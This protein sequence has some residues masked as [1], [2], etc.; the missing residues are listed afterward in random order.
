MSVSGESRTKKGL[1]SVK[2]LSFSGRSGYWREWSTKVLAYGRTKG[3]ESALTD[4]NA[5]KESKDEALNFLIMS[6]TGNAFIFVSHAKDPYL[7]WQELCS[8]YEPTEDMDLYDIKET[9][10]NC[11]L[12]HDTENVSIWLKRLENINKRLHEVD[13]SHSV[14]DSD[15]K[16]HIKANLPKKLYKVFL[17]TNRKNFKGMTYDELKKDLK[18]YW[19]QSIKINDGDFGDEEED[20]LAVEM[21]RRKV[22]RQ[23][24]NY[25][26]PF[27]GTCFN[28]GQIG[29]KSRD[30][31]EKKQKNKKRFDKTKVKCFKCGEYGHYASECKKDKTE[32]NW[33]VGMIE[34][35]ELTS[36]PDSDYG[37]EWTEVT[38]GGYHAN[39][40]VESSDEELEVLGTTNRYE[41]LSCE[42][43]EDWQPVLDNRVTVDLT[44]SEDESVNKLFS[45]DSEDEEREADA[46]DD[47]MKAEVVVITDGKDD[48]TAVKKGKVKSEKCNFVRYETHGEHNNVHT[49]KCRRRRTR[50]VMK[51]KQQNREKRNVCFEKRRKLRESFNDLQCKID[52]LA[53][54]L[55]LK[56]NNDINKFSID[57]DKT[58]KT[59]LSLRLSN[60]RNRL[61][62]ERERVCDCHHHHGRC[63]FHK[64]YLAMSNEKVTRLNQ[65]SDSVL[66]IDDGKHMG[67]GTYE[68]WL[69]DSGSTVHVTNVNQF[70]FNI[71]RTNSVVT[72]GT[73]NTVR[74]KYSGSVIIQQDK[75]QSVIVLNNVL[76]VPEF[77]QNII[78]VNSLLRQGYRMECDN[79][80]INLMHKTKALE[81]TKDN[82]HSM[83][84]L[85]GIRKEKNKNVRT[86]NKSVCNNLNAHKLDIQRKDESITPEALKD[87]VISMDIN[88]AHDSFGHVSEE[89]LRRF[90]KEHNIKLTGKMRTC[91]GC[92]EAK[93]KRKPVQKQ[94]EMRATRPCERIFIDTSGPHPQ[95]LRRYK[96]WIKIVDDFSR[97]NWNYFAKA[98]SE[99]PRIL[100]RFILM[101]KAQKKI[102]K[103]VRCDNAGEHMSE[104]Q[105]VCRKYQIKPEYVAPYTPQHNG[106]VERSFTT[107]LW[108]MKAMLRQ[109][110]F[111]QAT[112]HMFWPHAILVL[113]KI[114][115]M[116]YTS[117]NRGGKTPDQLFGCSSPD[118]SRH[119]I[120]FGRVGYVTIR[121]K[122]QGKM[123]P[124][125]HKCVMVGYADNHSADTYL[126]FNPKTRHI[127][128]SRDI[129]WAD[130]DRPKAIDDLNMYKT[131]EED[132]NEKH[133][134]S[135]PT[136]IEDNISEQGGRNVNDV[137]VENNNDSNSD[138]EIYI[139]IDSE[140]ESETE[141][142]I[143]DD[144][145]YESIDNNESEDNNQT[146]R[147]TD[148]T[149]RSNRSSNRISQQVERTR[150]VQRA[151]RKLDTSF[152]SEARKRLRGMN[153]TVHKI[154]NTAVISDPGEPKDIWEAIKEEKKTL[155]IPSIKAEI[156]NFV[157]RKSWEYVSKHEPEK[158]NR[159]LIPCKWVFKVKDEQDGSKRYKS[160]LCV[161]GFHQIPGVDY[162][163]SFSPVA[164]DATI[165][166][167]LLYT[168]WKYTEGWR[169][170][171][172]D[173]EAAFLNAE[174]ETPMYLKWPEAMYELGCITKHQLDNECIKLVRSMYGNVDAA[175]RWQKCFI[176]A[177]TD[178][179]GE[180]KCEQSKVDPCL[181][182]KRNEKNEVILLIVCYV[183][184]ILFSGTKEQIEW[185]K[186]TFKKLYKITELG[187][188]KKHLGMWYDWKKD[189]NGETYIKVTMDKM[190]KE[191]VEMYEKVTGKKVKDQNT[192]GYPNKC[193]TKLKDESQ[194][195]KVKE[196]RSL[197]GKILYYVNKMDVAC[198]NAVRELAQHLDSPG[199]EHWKALSRLVGYIKT[200]IGVG[201]IIRKP[202]ELRVVGWSDSDYAKREDRKSIGGNISTIGGSAVFGSSKGQSCVCLSS[203]EAE[204]V[205]MGT[206]AQ[207]IRFEQQL[208]DE[209]VGDEQIYPSIIYED[210]VGAIFLAQNRQVGQRTKHIDV[211]D[212]FIRGL[213]EAK[214]I[215]IVF[216]RSEDNYADILTKN[217]NQ[218]L[219][220]KHAND[221]DQGRLKYNS[222]PEKVVTIERD[223]LWMK[224]ERHFC[225]S[226]RNNI[227][228][229]EYIQEEN[230]SSQNEAT[231]RAE[232]VEEN[233]INDD[234]DESDDEQVNDVEESRSNTS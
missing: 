133:Q 195:F 194:I 172:F 2:S 144:N 220:K 226:I 175:L 80:R 99:V 39:A 59:Y 167:L 68:S 149:Q 51:R 19:R 154:Y 105:E 94:T 190:I 1:T 143:I 53:K 32:K 42:T 158:A 17:T 78:S 159:K 219:F 38:N 100:E 89:I 126:M 14:S 183:D 119:L 173:V 104:F 10:S 162:T 113:E 198:S 23:Q 227:D 215:K 186:K 47:V 130:F 179:N 193:L 120:E 122:F 217:V 69:I 118:I 6:L 165:Q 5:S 197:V 37:E 21:N 102:V 43:N 139:P 228:E 82:M 192:P 91:V 46:K 33:F 90:C 204:Y 187:C 209:I 12:K 135:V 171:M 22:H 177:C 214:Q 93:A 225:Y 152:N 70:M 11:R 111:K 163:E 210:N 218:E 95:S 146:G 191:I 56:V 232:T 3:W 24:V 48:D 55:E 97:K 207:E 54:L 150:K 168:L 58:L 121:K 125:S 60:Q 229:T 30:C 151:M 98:K 134:Q 205:A 156:M 124:R 45:S 52:K 50:K 199:E 201:K 203:T 196:Y 84:Y 29:H 35:E 142:E 7:V 145:D 106:V 153:N 81:I 63:V 161:K 25:T 86:F 26:K 231:A 85:Q 64:N 67:S 180:I 202:E 148:R 103:Y 41:V 137:A 200:R 13:P 222:T 88:I 128:L 176:K 116:T 71:Q 83:F 8:E 182:L 208:M 117:A 49:K 131:R 16:V 44:P 15:L 36:E 211:R 76:Y 185:F 138:N 87:K 40:V 189:H 184:D 132:R 28:C 20:V 75:T 96:Y 72:V 114:G 174:L 178:P 65:Q 92:K 166:I 18:A 147:E 140:S 141:D 233:D 136:I 223:D 34:K 62:S 216:T 234:S 77:N 79:N 206:L 9:F 164:T 155:W 230:E 27:K 169:C 31:P 213:I 181:L 160:R 123:K 108:R 57:V 212:H 224:E 109:A 110:C 115:N 188:M 127:I 157:K 107:D 129:Q 170:E 66:G 101:M 4:E 73:G 112:K 74:A 221:I 61:E